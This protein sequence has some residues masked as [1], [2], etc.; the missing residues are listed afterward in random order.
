VAPAQSICIEFP[1]KVRN[2][3]LL[4][5]APSE[6][7]QFEGR[8]VHVRVSLERAA[9]APTPTRRQRGYYFPVVCKQFGEFQGSSRQEMHMLLKLHFLG[10]VQPDNPV[11]PVRSIKSLTAHDFVDYVDQCV[12]LAAEMGCVLEP[13]DPAWRIRGYLQEWETAVGRAA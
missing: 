6:L 4:A 2:G 10:R 7:V 5:A 13:P 1:G 3:K 8:S 9:G 12:A 11:S